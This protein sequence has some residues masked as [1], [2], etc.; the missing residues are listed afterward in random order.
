MTLFSI[1]DP[2]SVI[3]AEVLKKYFKNE[4]DKKTTDILHKMQSS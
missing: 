4:K 1:A 2:S 3:F